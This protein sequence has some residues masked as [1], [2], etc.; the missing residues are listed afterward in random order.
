[1]GNNDKLFVDITGMLQGVVEHLLDSFFLFAANLADR[2]DG[3]VNQTQHRPDLQQAADK[4]L[5]AGAASAHVQVVQRI[6]NKLRFHLA[7][8]LFH[9][10]GNFQSTLAS[11]GCTG[12]LH[13]QEGNPSAQRLGIYDLHPAFRE[14]ACRE[15]GI[16]ICRG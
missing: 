1:M 13:D 11:G 12:S 9:H 6:H 8:A 15:Q 5:H 14:L 4:I 16:L 2:H 10:C 3:T 7:A